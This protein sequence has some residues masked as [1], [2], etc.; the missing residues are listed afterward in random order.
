MVILAKQ[1]TFPTAKIN[2]SEHSEMSP[3][4]EITNSEKKSPIMEV[5]QDLESKTPL[6]IRNPSSVTVI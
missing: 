1:N 2:I 5:T 4:N 6:E 3:I